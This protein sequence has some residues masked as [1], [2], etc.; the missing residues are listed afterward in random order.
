MIGAVGALHNFPLFGVTPHC[1]RCTRV[2]SVPSPAMNSRQRP[3]PVCK[4]PQPAPKVVSR[5][6]CCTQPCNPLST[7]YFALS[8][9]RP[10]DAAEPPVFLDGDQ[11]L[12]L[13][14]RSPATSSPQYAGS[15]R[16]VKPTKTLLL[17]DL[18]TAQKRPQ[19]VEHLPPLQQPPF[20][21]RLGGPRAIQKTSKYQWGIDPADPPSNTMG[22][23]SF[24]AALLAK[25]S[26]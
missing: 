24:S 15:H 6:L 22:V 17:W 21:K 2:G 8:L 19:F 11:L 10:Q 9:P 20:G 12:H 7:A 25:I 26:R 5:T 3:V 4:K 13:Q 14:R 18:R 23:L 1:H 16:G